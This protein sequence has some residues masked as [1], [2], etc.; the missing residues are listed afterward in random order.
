MLTEVKS[1]LKVIFMSVKY[2][3]IREMTNS[4]SFILNVVMMMLNNASFIIQWA[5]LFS[6]KESFGSFGFEEVM[7]L[8]GISSTSFGIAHVVFGGTFYLPKLIEDGKLDSF[9]VRP[10]NTLLMVITSKTIVSAIGDF[11]YGVVITLI[12]W[13]EPNQIL[14]FAFFSVTAALIYTALCICFYSL[15]FYFVKFSDAA[16]S[17]RSI[18]LNFSIYPAEIFNKAIKIIMFTIIPAGIAI[19]LP[20][21]VI[22]DF[23]IKYLIIVILFTIFIICLAFIMFYKGLKR[24]TSS[25]LMS[26]RT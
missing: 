23:N 25:N 26:A 6:L 5:V 8:W 19:Y 24:Y 22:M 1:H 2:N 7:L 17:L 15:S 4:V 16:D 3:I 13:H 12:F 9:L 21:E 20:V 10:K 11:L 14:L 18:F